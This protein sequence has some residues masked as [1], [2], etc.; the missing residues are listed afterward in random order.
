MA[1]DN[2]RLLG[3][4]R[5][6]DI[7]ELFR[8]ENWSNVDEYAYEALRPTLHLASQFL[9]MEISLQRFAAFRYGRQKHLPRGKSTY[10]DVG[11]HSIADVEYYLRNTLSSSIVISFG[12]VGDGTYGRTSTD[13]VTGNV[14][15]WLA[16]RFHAFVE[17]ELVPSIRR[18]SLPRP[19]AGIMQFQLVVAVALVHEVCHAIWQDRSRTRYGYLTPEP[20]Y[21]GEAVELRELG[22][23]WEQLVFAGMLNSRPHEINSDTGMA[24]TRLKLRLYGRTGHAAEL[25]VP[26]N[27]IRDIQTEEFWRQP[28]PHLRT[29]LANIL[30]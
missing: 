11:P 13:R 10:Y 3:G 18:G 14:L 23:S 12:P 7:H 1:Y 16:D 29:N 15:I 17:R 2:S 24:V 5:G 28:Q 21:A 19:D 6:S 4:S 25:M 8:F 30:L 27:Y 20:C 9:T 26:F 22:H